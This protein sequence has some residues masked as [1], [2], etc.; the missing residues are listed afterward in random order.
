[1]A[2]AVVRNLLLQL[3][4]DLRPLWPRPDQAHLA[5]QHRP[6]LR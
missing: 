4:L 3:L 6:K 2:E 1:M 5:P